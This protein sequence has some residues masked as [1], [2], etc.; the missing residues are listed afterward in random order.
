M[1]N[2]KSVIPK[3]EADLVKYCEQIG[4]RQPPKLV[5][6]FEAHEKACEH[7]GGGG[8]SYKNYLGMCCRDHGVVTVDLKT[9]R[10]T[11]NTVYKWV[12]CKKSSPYATMKHLKR[13]P[14]AYREARQVLVH[15]LVHYRWKSFD[16]GRRQWLRV[17]EILAG[18]TFELEP[19]RE[20]DTENQPS[21]N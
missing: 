6:S 19:P 13:V 15:E 17:R 20:A 16:E 14:W 5:F 7:E 3:L 1:K 8:R 11:V 9:P 12:K 2:K 18:K 4:I 10:S 21:P